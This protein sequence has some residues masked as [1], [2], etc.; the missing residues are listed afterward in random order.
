MAGSGPGDRTAITT[1]ATASSRLA[2]PATASGVTSQDGAGGRPQP[3]QTNAKNPSTATVTPR[4]RPAGHPP[5]VLA[6]RASSQPAG[7]RT[8]HRG[9]QRGRLAAEILR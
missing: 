5:D 4:L 3:N 9:R 8:P 7:P 6:I 1:P 2:A